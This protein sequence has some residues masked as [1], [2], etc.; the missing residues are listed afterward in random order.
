M[1][2]ASANQQAWNNYR[3]HEAQKQIDAIAER[4]SSRVRIHFA[5]DVQLH[6]QLQADATLVSPMP[7][8]W[9][10]MLVTQPQRE[11]LSHSLLL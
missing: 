2:V 8:S 3:Q 11:E 1:R 7:P 9:T 10:R 4:A 6:H 5:A